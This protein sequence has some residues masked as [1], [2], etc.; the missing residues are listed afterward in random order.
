[1]ANKVTLIIK[2]GPMAGKTIEFLEHDT[3]IFGRMN[4]CHICLPDDKYLSRHHFILET[5]PP[6][7]RIRDLG[8][9]N[10]THVNKRKIGGRLPNETPEEGA[11]RDYPQVDLHHNDVI[12]TGSTMF[13]FTKEVDILPKAII[14]CQRCGK[15]VSAQAGANRHGDFLCLNCINELEQDPKAII[16]ALF[17]LPPKSISQINIPDYEVLQ[18]LGKGGMGEVFQVKNKITGNLAAIKLMLPRVAV[19]EVAREK[20]FRE[21]QTISTLHHPN[22]VEF[23]SSGASGNIFFIIM[24]YCNNRNLI[25]LIQNLGRPLTEK[26]AIPILLQVSEGLAYAHSR[27]LV[28]RDIKPQN[29]LLNKENGSIIAKISDFGLAKNFTQAGFSGMTLTGNYSGSLPFMPREQV[30]NFKYVK[31]VSDVWSLAA[32]FYFILTGELPRE[33]RRGQDPLEAI[34]SGKIV[35]LHDRKIDITRKLA[36]IIDK[37]LATDPRDRYK[38]ATQ[39]R[40]DLGRLI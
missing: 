17:N 7:A 12:E 19:S 39:M 10:G 16:Q 26:E 33:I 18:L 1:M 20:F 24:E 37:A 23:F 25:D 5:N 6:D 31:P 29:I 40:K 35:P 32:T 34:L 2:S 14:H 15:D 4:D 3:L 30:T 28:H 8:S 22:I 36:L 38:D 27:N 9:L 11:R 13:E 21:I